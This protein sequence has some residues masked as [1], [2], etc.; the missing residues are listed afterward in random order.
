MQFTQIKDSE[1]PLKTISHGVPQGSVL[2]PLLFLIFI[3]DMHNSI[4]HCKMHRFADDTNLLLTDKSLKNINKY[5]NY[6]L[7][8]ICHWLRANKLSLNASKTVIIIF[9]PKNKQIK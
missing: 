2:G 1:S 7:S 6:D 9:R 5:V 4:E 8:L 3:N